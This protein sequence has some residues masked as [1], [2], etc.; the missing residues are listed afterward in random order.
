MGET[1]LVLY[2]VSEMNKDHI[3]ALTANGGK[4]EAG[5]AL[6]WGWKGGERRLLVF[7][8]PKFMLF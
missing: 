5:W 7:S 2:Y 4:G 1:A 3:L 6:A 8:R